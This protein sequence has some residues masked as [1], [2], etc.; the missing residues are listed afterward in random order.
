MTTMRCPFPLCLSAATSAG[1][2]DGVSVA[3]GNLL[4]ADH[5]VTL[6]EEAL[7]VVPEPFLSIAALEGG[8][9]L[10]A[11]FSPDDST[12]FQTRLDQGSPDTCGARLRSRKVC[13]GRYAV[14]PARCATGDNAD[15]DQRE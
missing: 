11:P 1:Y 5:G 15:G 4:L 2:R 8:R 14:G 9:P 12:P 3:R 13:V 6:A 7:G 10:Y